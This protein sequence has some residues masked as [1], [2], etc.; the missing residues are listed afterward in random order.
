MSQALVLHSS[1]HGSESGQASGRLETSGEAQ[2]Q[3]KGS[4]RGLNPHTSVTSVTRSD[5]EPANTAA[6]APSHA[7]CK[8]MCPVHLAGF[9][10]ERRKNTTKPPFFQIRQKTIFCVFFINHRFY[11]IW[12]LFQ[13]SLQ[14]CTP[15]QFKKK[16]NLYI[17][18][19]TYT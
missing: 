3:G 17:Y 1:A 16:L 12:L 15:S 5:S 2:Q 18:T 19:H 8:N 9:L 10:F 13:L 7:I 6:A 11:F 14:Y 4:L